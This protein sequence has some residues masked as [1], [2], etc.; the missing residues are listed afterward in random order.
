MILYSNYTESNKGS[1]YINNSDDLFSINGAFEIKDFL[2]NEI[3]AGTISIKRDLIF[4]N[5]KNFICSGTNKIILTG[6]TVQTI[7]LNSSNVTLNDLEIQNPVEVKVEGLKPL[8]VNKLIL[9][10]S[11]TKINLDDFEYNEIVTL[12]EIGKFNLKQGWNMIAFPSTK[13]VKFDD[14][15]KNIPSLWIFSNG[16]W[17][18]WSSNISS[19][20]NL[21]FSLASEVSPGQGIWVYANSDSEI[22]YEKNSTSYSILE[23]NIALENGWN[24]LGTGENLTVSAFINAYPT[25]KAV[26]KWNASTQ[27]WEGSSTSAELKQIIQDS[28][29]TPFSTIYAGEG[30]WAYTGN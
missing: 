28:G 10:N 15:F 24:F 3:T 12:V 22:T 27:S 17:G 23:L 5:T 4:S 30:F 14:Y 11:S 26:F 6:D 8:K 9:T 29:I 16:N 25:V 21:G 2:V 18:V 1:L 7:K 19:V 20:S 13:T